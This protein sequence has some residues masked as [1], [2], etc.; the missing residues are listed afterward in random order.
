MAWRLPRRALPV[1]GFPCGFGMNPPSTG[2]RPAPHPISAHEI[3]GFRDITRSG[4][5]HAG[6]V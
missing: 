6:S 4:R 5:S 2:R 1:D 3:T